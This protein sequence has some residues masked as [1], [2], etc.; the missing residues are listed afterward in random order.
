MCRIKHPTLIWDNIIN[1]CPFKHVE[2]LLLTHKNNNILYTLVENKVFQVTN[3]TQI[4]GDINVIQTAEGLYLS[5]DKKSKDLEKSDKSIKLIDELL[6]AEIDSKDYKLMSL[7]L[8]LSQLTNEKMC[9]LYKSFINLYTK[10]DDEF[11]KFTDFHG[12]EAVLYSDQGRIFIPQCMKIESIDVITETKYCY[13]DFPVRIVIKNE[14]INAFLTSEKIIKTTSKKVSCNNH[15]E[16]IHLKESKR[17][18][19]KQKNKIILEKDDKYT[20]IKFNLQQLNVTEINF[21]HDEN[22]L[23]SVNIIEKVSDLTKVDEI[24]GVMHVSDDKYSETHAK[25]QDLINLNYDETTTIV[26]K[27]VLKFC[28]ALVLIIIGLLVVGRIIYLLLTKE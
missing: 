14:T 10:L 18:L 12:N 28:T 17:I 16:N 11:F 23:N 25:I 4:C 20:H 9:Q 6:L 15:H 8:R 2:S 1:E 24:E 26:Q 5:T 3:K 22:I 21:K 7:L 13:K 19:S 27:F